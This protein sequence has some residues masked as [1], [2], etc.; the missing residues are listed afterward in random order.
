MDGVKVK[1]YLFRI[2]ISLL[3]L[4]ILQGCVPIIAAGVGTGAILAQD[5]RSAGTVI[6]DKTDE[7]A[8]SQNISKEL[9][10]KASISVTVYD[11]KVLLTGVAINTNVKIKAGEIA[12]SRPGIKAVY[13]Q[14]R[15]AVA[16]GLVRDASDS[17]ITSMVKARMINQKGLNAEHVKVVTD[18]HIVYL[19]GIVTQ[20]EANLAAQCAS[21]TEGVSKVI[22]LFEYMN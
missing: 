7:L 19:M 9:K 15:L 6:D 5:R 20:Q 21:T 14:V 11:H 8:I 13:N 16:S 17:V 4:P 12:Q 10:K 1:K 22:T 3:L 2:M 18:D